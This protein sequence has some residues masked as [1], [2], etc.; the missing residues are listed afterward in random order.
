MNAESLERCGLE[1]FEKAIHGRF[2]CKHP[3]VKLKREVMFAERVLHQTAFASLH[4][5]LFGREIGKKF[6][7]IVKASFGSEKFTCRDVEKSYTVD[8]F[9]EMYCRQEVVF[10]MV[11][12]VVVDGDTGGDELSDAAFY[13]FLGCLRI[14]KL[15]AYSYAL[16]GS[17]QLWKIGVKCMM[18]K[19][20]EFHILRSA[21]GTSGQSYAEDFGCGDGIL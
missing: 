8:L 7:D 3:V 11:K 14:L 6:F 10:P 12:D 4:K 15:L 19:S 18:G 20:G 9:A 1:L 13:Q 5:H 2:A 21:V 17:N 16:T